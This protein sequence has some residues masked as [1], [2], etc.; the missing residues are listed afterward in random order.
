MNK[1]ITPSSYLEK[2][3]R[4][5][6][7]MSLSLH[8]GGNDTVCEHC[9]YTEP[10]GNAVVVTFISSCLSEYASQLE[11]DTVFLK[12]SEFTIRECMEG[13][14]LLPLFIERAEQ[15]QSASGLLNT[16]GIGLGLKVVEDVKGL[17][18]SR[19]TMKSPAINVAAN[20][21]F[22]AEVLH[23]TIDLTKKMGTRFYGNQICLDYMPCVN[24]IVD[25]SGSS[26]EKLH[27]A[28]Q[29]AAQQQTLGAPGERR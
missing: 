26:S 2:C 15:I 24:P 20:M 18:V 19:V 27:K 14:G 1:Q 21:C 11:L 13:N 25:V 22:L 3:P 28:L 23:E 8:I 16:P 7:A 12:G 17:L 4:C 5:N 9:E 6:T 10:A 29:A